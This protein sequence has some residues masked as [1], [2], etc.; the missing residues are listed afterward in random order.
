MKGTLDDH[1]AQFAESNR[2]EAAGAENEENVE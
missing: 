1:K 2:A